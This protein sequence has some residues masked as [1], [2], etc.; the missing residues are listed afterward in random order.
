LHVM[1]HCPDVQ[2]TA[3]EFA[4]FGHAVEHPPQ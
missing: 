2:A 1:T 3:E 4:G